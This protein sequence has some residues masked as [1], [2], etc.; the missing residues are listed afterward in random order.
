MTPPTTATTA[1]PGAKLT[2][3]FTTEEK[4][5]PIAYYRAHDCKSCPLKARCT[6]NQGNRTHHA[7]GL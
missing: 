2:Y 7:G 5:R 1:R 6:R 3:R 4:G